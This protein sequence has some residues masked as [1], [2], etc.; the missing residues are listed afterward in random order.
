V[1]VPLDGTAAALA[2]V[3]V[4]R[5]LAALEGG[6]LR[7]L[8][9]ADAPTH[10][11]SLLRKLGLSADQFDGGVFEQASGPPVEA[12]LHLA[13]VSASPT[14]VACIH[15]D[16]A[17][18]FGWLGSIAEALLRQSRAPLLLVH[19]ERG[20]APWALH[21]IL[22]PHDGTPITAAA[23]GPAF[24]LADRASAEVIVLHVS[25]SKAEPPEPGSLSGP[26]YIDQPQHEWPAWAGEFLDRLTAAAGRVPPADV[27]ICLCHGEAGSE[28]LHW[29]EAEVADLI[30]LAWRG[31]FDAER[32]TTLKRVIRA[33]PCPV[34]VLRAI[35]TTPKGVAPH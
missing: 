11:P 18:P 32:A 34:L 8:H 20:S 14:V 23:V 2:A 21:R 24:D 35:P 5:G 31:R 19:P 33:A 1:I 16:A 28:I 22:L 4:A 25:N 15:T 29:A 10:G 13:E 17:K 6:T 26:R 12:I 7:F 3:P 9:V 30:V 27:R